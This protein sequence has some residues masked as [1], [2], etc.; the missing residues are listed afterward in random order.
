MAKRVRSHLEII[1]NAG[2]GPYGIVRSG[3][4]GR[5]GRWQLYKLWQFKSVINLAH[6][7]ETDKQDKREKRWCEKRGIPY[8]QFAWGSSSPPQDLNEFY[9]AV[10]IFYNAPKPVWIHCEGGRDRTGGFV[11]YIRRDQGDDWEEVVKDF[12]N[13][14]PPNHGWLAFVFAAK[15]G[16][17]RPLMPPSPP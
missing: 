4:P 10:Q 9:E 3:Q 7:P 17:D 2:K 13:H 15:H 6:R 8:Y 16:F 11:A 5:F 14:G 1:Y 12:C